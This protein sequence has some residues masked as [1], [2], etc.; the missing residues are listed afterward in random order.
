MNVPDK[1]VAGAGEVAVTV[2]D[3]D[4]KPVGARARAAKSSGDRWKGTA[5]TVDC[6]ERAEL[7]QLMAGIWPDYDDY[8]AK[9]DRE[10]PLVR[11]PETRL[12]D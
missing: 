12:A 1:D 9:T 4:D 3:A 11:F 8:Q 10:I 7:W 5:R 6:D 2:V